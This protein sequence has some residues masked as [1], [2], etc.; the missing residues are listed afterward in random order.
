MT[1]KNME[2]ILKEA[3]AHQEAVAMVQ[4]VGGDKEALHEL[5]K[6]VGI[7]PHYIEQAR[8]ALSPTRAERDADRKRVG[9]RMSFDRMY[10]EYATRLHGALEREI[11]GK[12][13]LD[14]E[15]KYDTWSDR[16]KGHYNS[17]L[18]LPPE[19]LWQKIKP[20]K[21]LL[22]KTE[23]TQGLS[24]DMHVTIHVATPQILQAIS[25]Q[26]EKM[27]EEFSVHKNVVTYYR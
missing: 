8:R 12:W 26:I 23:F 6:T 7:D 4:A 2:M 18:I 24:E 27:D 5:A 10:Q 17:N 25:G 3:A 9:G 22:L 13:N 11:R 21:R 15:V 19:N 14:G 20:K 1:H 16:F